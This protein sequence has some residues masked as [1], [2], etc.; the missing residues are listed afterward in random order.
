[1]KFSWGNIFILMLGE[2]QDYL[3]LEPFWV[4]VVEDLAY[5][6]LYHHAQLISWPKEDLA[7]KRNEVKKPNRIIAQK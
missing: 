3:K 6:H 4:W 7:Q 1:M 5:D 2:Y